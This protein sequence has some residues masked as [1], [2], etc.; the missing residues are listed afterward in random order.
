ATGQLYWSNQT[1]VTF[2][3]AISNAVYQVQTA[4]NLSLGPRTWSSL[5]GFNAVRAT[6]SVASVRLAAAKETRFYRVQWLNPVLADSEIDFSG[7]QGLKNWYY[8]YY[9]GVFTSTGFNIMTVFDGTT[10]YENE[11]LYWTQI[12]R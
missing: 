9:D 7:T 5:P 6:G 2:P 12:D 8:G 4:T 1:R 3:A 10:W 11:S